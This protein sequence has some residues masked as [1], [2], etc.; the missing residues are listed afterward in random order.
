MGNSY[1]IKRL[2][3][4]I[5]MKK[6]FYLAS[7]I[8]V[9]TSCG[10]GEI[11]PEDEI[12]A[13]VNEYIKTDHDFQYFANPKSD[14]KLLLS[15][16]LEKPDNFTDPFTVK[17]DT[18]FSKEDIAYM[19]KQAEDTIPFL[20]KTTKLRLPNTVKLVN[21]DSLRPPK[22]KN[23]WDSLYEKNGL[24]CIVTIGKP[25]FTKDHKTALIDIAS[26]AGSLA[27][28]G[29]RVILRKDKGRWKVVKSILR[30]IS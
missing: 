30:W 9:I 12:Y 29:S 5:D 11:S 16:K 28:T 18:L 8:I 26:S 6:L 10:S 25:V 13:I 2:D 17:P 22:G 23:F 3:K 24:V 7:T 4:L 27:G 20:L 15:H 1:S 14:V 21:N 19:M